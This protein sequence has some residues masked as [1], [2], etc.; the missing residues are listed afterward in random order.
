MIQPRPASKGNF[1][2]PRKI[3]KPFLMTRLVIKEE[4]V[5]AQVPPEQ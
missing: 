5:A 3:Q 2:R 1:L 4:R